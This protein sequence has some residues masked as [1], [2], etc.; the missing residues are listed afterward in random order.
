MPL[1][2]AERDYNPPM[3]SAAKSP[4]CPEQT[5][6]IRLVVDSMPTLAWSARSDGSADFF[7]QCWLDYTG[8]FTE[9]SLGWV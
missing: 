8:L 1:G 7:N 4:E 3:A 6:D 2:I 5:Q 9:Q